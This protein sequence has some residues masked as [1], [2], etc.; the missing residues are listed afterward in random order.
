[1]RLARPIIIMGKSMAVAHAGKVQRTVG[2]K[3]YRGPLRLRRA[4][5]AARYCLFRARKRHSKIRGL[6]VIA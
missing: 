2:R 3:S 1:M 4:G 5:A 6:S